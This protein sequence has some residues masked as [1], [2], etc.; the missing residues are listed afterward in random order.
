[1]SIFWIVD[2]TTTQC[3]PVLYGKVWADELDKHNVIQYLLCI[4]NF[5]SPS[6]PTLTVENVKEVMGEVEKWEVVGSVLHVPH[7][8]LQEIRQ[9]SSTERERSL[10][11]GEYW[12]NIA[13]HASWERLAC[14]LYEYGEER[15]AAIAKKYLQQGVT[16]LK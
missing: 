15:A 4:C 8:K 1:M 14:A 9:Q 10:A 7:S 12:V 6:D 11:L 5:V 2:R 3:T 13:P 16:I